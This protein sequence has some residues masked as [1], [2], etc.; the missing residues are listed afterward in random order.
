MKVVAT[1]TRT[2]RSTLTRKQ[3][4]PFKLT[5]LMVRKVTSSSD[6]GFKV[7]SS[8][9]TRF[10]KVL[11]SGGAEAVGALSTTLPLG[12]PMLG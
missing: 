6:L 3:Q 8:K 5:C 9:C 11:G 7:E 2:W 12:P 1:V 4:Y 10:L